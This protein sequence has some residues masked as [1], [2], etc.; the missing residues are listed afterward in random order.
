[1]HLYDSTYKSLQFERTGLFK[2]IAETYHS[3][4]VLYPGCSVHI[5]PS[6]YFPHVAY[7]DQSE[8][9]A[10]FFA[11]EG[12]ILDF[13]NRNKHYKG[14]TYLRFIRQDYSQHLPV[15]EKS[16]DLLLALFAG[17]IAKACHTYLKLG[18][19]L[20]TNNQQGDAWE[21]LQPGN[22]ELKARVI[23]HKK[24]YVISEDVD[25]CEI[26]A[27]KLS[28]HYLKQADRGISYLERETYYIFQRLR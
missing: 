17:G 27:Q 28:H 11:E 14:S 15:R 20:L 7:V 19:F 21:A 13:V 12:S 24:A 25:K 3:R 8:A 26:T 4:E 2:A 6:L 10:H 23:F 9:A 16:F 5:T 22:L 18:G 1:M